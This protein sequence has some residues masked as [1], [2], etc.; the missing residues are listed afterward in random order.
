MGPHI[1]EACKE[2]S[3]IQYSVQRFVN[4][5]EARL[6]LKLIPQ[7]V[8]TTTTNVNSATTLG[9]PS[10]SRP[11]G[12]NPSN[13]KNNEGNNSEAEGGKKKKGDKYFSIYTVYT[14]LTDTRENIF[15]ANEN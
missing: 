8:I 15:I 12:D 14:E 2:N 4:V 11:S 6:A 9:M 13:R 3:R 10:T 7:P 5:E 1:E